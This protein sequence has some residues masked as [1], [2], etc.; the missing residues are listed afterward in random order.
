MT[1]AKYTL[2][3]TALDITGD[4]SL[5][6]CEALVE[7]MRQ[8]KDTAQWAV[9]DALLYASER[10]PE[11]Y[12]QILDDT[13]WALQTARNYMTTARRIPR[14][15]RRK[16]VSFSNHSELTSLSETD[17]VYALDK[18]DAKAWSRDDL[19]TWKRERRGTPEPSEEVI[20][21]QVKAYTV[22]DG[23]LTVSFVEP[24]NVLDVIGYQAI[25]VIR[26]PATQ[27]AVA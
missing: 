20:T 15:V 7:Q 18:L 26:K 13:N 23:I 25:R 11:T 9:A 12:E 17:M 4:L 24:E 5:A 2:T 19:R 10:Y 22:K 14:A 16:G 1:T 3:D 27:E 6:E 8:G 21:L